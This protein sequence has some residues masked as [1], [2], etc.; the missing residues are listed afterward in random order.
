M[1]R[2]DDKEWFQY[3]V[4]N[5]SWDPAE[6]DIH[7][8]KVA[9]DL[10]P[11][12]IRTWPNDLSNYEK[13]GGKIIT[14]HGQQDGKITSFNTERFYNHLATAMNMTSSELDNFFRYFR[15]SGMSHCSSGPGAW[16]FGQG[17]SPSP[18]MTPFNGNENILAA[19][20]AWV[21]HGVAPETITGTKYV[22]DNPELGI[23]FQRSHCRF[24]IQLNHGR[25]VL[26]Y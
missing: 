11:Q 9:D 8:A 14:F 26:C 23:S 2:H 6:F 4:Y 16:A 25:H 13:R 1:L 17:G 12:N 19:L 10:N 7:D 21:E 18:A 22:D 15:I 24:V 5:P 20:V 3:V